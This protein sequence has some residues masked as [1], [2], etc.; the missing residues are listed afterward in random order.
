MGKFL[1]QLITGLSIGGIYALLAV[2]YALIYS[3]FDFTNFAF[4][5]I[6]MLGSFTCLFAINA[7]HLPM[8]LTVI[9]V[10]LFSILASLLTDQVAYKPMRAKGSS[11]LTLMIAAMG[12]DIFIV[13]LM[14]VLYGGN[15][16]QIDYDWPIRTIK[17]GPAN[18]GVID[19]LSLISALIILVILWLFLYKSIYGVA[20]RASATDIKTAGLMGINTNT[21]AVL[22]FAVSGVCAGVTGFFYGFKYAVYPAMGSI[23]TKAFIASVIGGLGS[24]PGAVAGGLILGILETMIAGYISSTYRDLFSYSVLILVL[25]FMPNGLLGKN[26]KDKS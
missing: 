17:I 25:L 14:T 11:R 1:Q 18:V 20:I 5:S 19:L 10:I 3:I 7:F 26:N 13:N 24:L 8:W 6:M 4:G 12:V 16:R 21:I 15:I 23:A 2:G 22:V 9:A